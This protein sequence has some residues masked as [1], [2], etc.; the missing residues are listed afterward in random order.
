MTTT[1]TIGGNEMTQVLWLSGMNWE[2][3]SQESIDYFFS[4]I[5]Q[6]SDRQVEALGAIKN[7]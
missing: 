2:K 1:Y 5:S 4:V 7:A 6:L 3:A